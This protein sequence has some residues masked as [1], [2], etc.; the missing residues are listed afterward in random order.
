[1]N[2]K[3][4]LKLAE[5]LRQP[6]NILLTVTSLGIILSLIIYFQILHPIALTN[7]VLTEK[8]EDLEGQ[9]KIIESMPSPAELNEADF[10]QLF[11]RVPVQDRLPDFMLELRELERKSGVYISEITLNETEGTVDAVNLLAGENKITQTNE[12][13]KKNSKKSKEEEA[14]LITSLPIQIS[15]AGRSYEQISE[16]MKELHDMERIATIKTWDISAADTEP[17]QV[18]IGIQLYKTEKYA[19]LYNELNKEP[20]PIFLK[21]TKDKDPTLSDKQFF[22]QLRE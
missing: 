18:E 13:S 21:P 14:P 5:K 4:W 6:H 10:L 1:M 12:D 17:L 15:A 9:R 2:K 22:E 11:E 19:E 7:Q 3:K 8:L 20:Q 16:F